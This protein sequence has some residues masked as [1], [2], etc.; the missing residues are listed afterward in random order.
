MEGGGRGAKPGQWG[1]NWP[2]SPLQCE[3]I[4]VCSREGTV[5]SLP[6]EAFPVRERRDFDS[7]VTNIALGL[8]ALMVLPYAVSQWIQSAAAAAQLEAERKRLGRDLLIR[9]AFSGQTG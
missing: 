9:I 1:E 6:L 7:R 8:L 4:A 5:I 3:H 2:G